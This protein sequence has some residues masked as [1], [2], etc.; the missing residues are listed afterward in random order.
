MKPWPF[1]SSPFGRAS[2]VCALLN[3]LIF[4]VVSA[5][6]LA[7]KVFLVFLKGLSLGTLQLIFIF[8]FFALLIVVF[9]ISLVGVILS[10]G[11]LYTREERPVLAVLGLILNIVPLVM[12]VLM[13]TLR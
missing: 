13:R 8:G 11:S 9:V 3:I 6:Y 7:P 5:F 12:V 1:K 2:L 10:V 4:A